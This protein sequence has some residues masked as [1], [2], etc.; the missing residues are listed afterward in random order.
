[1][2]LVLA[3]DQGTT[4]SR[5]MAFD[6]AGTIR[7]RAQQ[8]LPQ[9]FPRTGWVEHDPM[10]IWKAQRETLEAC[11]AQVGDE[12][13]AALGITNQRETTIL[14]DRATGR[15]IHN[16]I[17]WQDRRTADVCTRLR[18]EGVEPELR[19]KTG[20]LLDPYFS[21]TKIRWLL[22]N[23]S[24][25]RARA[26]RG[27]L[28]F[29]TVD[30]WLVWNL[31]EGRAHITD[32]SNASRTLLYD[33]RAGCWDEDLLTLF[34]IPPAL[35]PT[36]GPSSGT[37]AEA[38]IG[39]RRFPIAGLA[40]DQ[41]AALFGQ[42]CFVPGQAKNTYG[43]GCFLLLHTGTD[44]V[45]SA[46]R[47]LTTVAWEVDGV[48][49]YALEGS[50]FMGGATIQ[51]LHDG[52]GLIENPADVD[53]LART[54]PDAGGVYFVP[55][56]AGLGAPHWD[57]QARGIL[58]GLTRGTEKGHIARAALEGI[59]FQVADVLDAM[60]EDAGLPLAELRVDGGASASDLLLQIQ[61]DILQRRVQR[62]TITET[63]ALGAAY[64]A[65]LGVGLWPD[66]KTIA[67]RWQLDAEARPQMSPEDAAALRRQWDRAVQRSR[68]WAS[69]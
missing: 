20:L 56:M 47:L 45:R 55:A 41:Q 13:V 24:G 33:I 31:S 63:T 43:T 36:V 34:D 62:P 53:A 39:G 69:A 57:P 32:P 27:E 44:A 3:L 23:V 52:L 11:L 21:A 30:S 26:E 2:A 1:M 12:P 46:H 19:D 14:W 28:A 29:G 48:R 6:D 42:G 5:T 18:E 8:A 59:A 7:G 25:A 16:A 68:H 65:G 66:R 37:L 54:V 58:L 9:H 50:V 35:L 10:E 17:V 60:S 38:R 4:S 64:L 49:E 22:E 61:A 67:T 51:W 15:P 40:G